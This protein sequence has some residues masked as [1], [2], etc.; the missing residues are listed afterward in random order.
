MTYYINDTSNEI[1]VLI[2]SDRSEANVFASWALEVS[3]IRSIEIEL[4]PYTTTAEGE[5]LLGYYG[6]S[7]DS[8]VDN[9]FACMPQRSK[10][11]LN[12]SMVKMLLRFP[13]L[14]KNECCLL[15]GKQPTHY[16]RVSRLMSQHCMKV[17]ELSGGRNPMKLLRGIRSDL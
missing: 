4:S 17:S 14:S 6:F 1:T 3:Q 5:R 12:K 11:W 7:I 10:T 8:L 16:S 13:E 9:I 2:C 15:T